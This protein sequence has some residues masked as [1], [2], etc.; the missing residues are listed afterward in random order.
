MRPRR[1]SHR[2][3][4]YALIGAAI[5]AVVFAVISAIVSSNALSLVNGLALG[6]IVGFVIGILPAAEQDDQDK[7]DL[8]ERARHGRS[9]PADATF[10]GQEARDLAEQR[11]SAR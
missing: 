7:Q 11:E 4:T 3:I 5:G 10:E 8:M 6:L 2:V 1:R 9:C